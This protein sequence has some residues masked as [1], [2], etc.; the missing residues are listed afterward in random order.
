MELIVTHIGADFDA[1]GAMIAARRLH[2]DGV[3]F[4]P[5]QK[6]NPSAGFWSGA[7]P[8]SKSSGSDRS[9]RAP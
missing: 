7:G 9:T 4:F 3:L 2:P 8:G 5:G 1:L 6:K